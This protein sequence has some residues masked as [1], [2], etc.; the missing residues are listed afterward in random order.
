MEFEFLANAREMIPT[1]GYLYHNEW[2]QRLYG[3]SREESIAK[4]DDYLNTESLPLI[5]VANENRNLLAAAKLRRYEM[6]E[7][8]PDKEFWLGGVFVSERQRG[9]GVG[10]K[11]VSEILSIAPNYGVSALYLQ[12]EDLKGGMYA[13]LGWEPLKQVT[14]KAKKVLVMER[15]VYA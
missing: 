15:H 8:F 1:L 14:N 6:K 2:G 10:A 3:E 12:T 11:L 9:R 4:L 13:S 5:L 7:Q